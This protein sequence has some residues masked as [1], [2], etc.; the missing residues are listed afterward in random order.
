MAE[1][2]LKGINF[3]GLEDTYIIPQVDDTLT[4]S[5]ASADAKVVGDSLNGMIP[6]ILDSSLCGTSLPAAGTPGRIFFK[7]VSS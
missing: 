6:K 3:P 2:L 5:G 7:K 4:V 1:K